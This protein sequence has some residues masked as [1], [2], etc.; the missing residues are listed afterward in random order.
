[1]S[2]NFLDVIEIYAKDNPKLLDKSWRLSK[3]SG[4]YWIKGKD[5]RPVVFQPN[6]AQEILLN[7]SHPLKIIPKSR[8][9]GITTFYAI[10]YLDDCIFSPTPIDTTF[11]A[12]RRENAELI[13]E[14]KIRFA[15]ER[16]PDY[17]R[18]LNPA[19]KESTRMLRWGNGSSYVVDTA[20]RGGTFQRLHVSEFG[21]ICARYP[22]KAQEI[23]EGALETVAVGQQ[24]TIE[25]TSEGRGGYFFDMCKQAEEL[26]NSGEKLGL[27]DYKLFFFPWWKEPTYTL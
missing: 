19:S 11:I 2:H 23:I 14:N 21:K 13:F 25:S 17:I 9:L 27:L 3:E 12:D 26:K 15:W 20:P 16:V 22:Q 8:Q 24:I 18:A 10:N 7:E 4:F 6:W 1:M 5:G